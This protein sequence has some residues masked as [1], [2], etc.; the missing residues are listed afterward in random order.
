MTKENQKKLMVQK[1]HET[2]FSETLHK[3]RESQKTLGTIEKK[4]F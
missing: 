3:F 1:N 2:D 4:F